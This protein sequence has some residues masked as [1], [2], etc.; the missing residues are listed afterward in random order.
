MINIKIKKVTNKKGVYFIVKQK[1]RFF[2]ETIFGSGH[3]ENVSDC[4]DFIKSKYKE[5]SYEIKYDKEW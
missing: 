1:E 5:G 4:L 3:Y 2:W